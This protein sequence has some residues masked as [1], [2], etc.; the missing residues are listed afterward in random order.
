MGLGWRIGESNGTKDHKRREGL[1]LWLCKWKSWDEW[2]GRNSS[3]LA[4]LFL[5]FWIGLVYTFFVGH[6]NLDGVDV[7]IDGNEATKVT[8]EVSW[9]NT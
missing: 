1:L 9:K 4:F 5:L 3:G 6:V 2:N 7:L 8:R